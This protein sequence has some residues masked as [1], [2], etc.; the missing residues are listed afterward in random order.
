[1]IEALN[2]DYVEA[3]IMRG[4]SPTRILWR[5]ALPTALPPIIQVIGINVLYLAGGIVVVEYIFNYPGIGQLLISSISDRDTSTLQFIVIL[6]A[7]FYV[8]V[9]I[10]TDLISLLVTPRRRLPRWA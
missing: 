2:S 10:T 5:H 9:N 6:L 3:A 4:I 1:M 7:A 8:L